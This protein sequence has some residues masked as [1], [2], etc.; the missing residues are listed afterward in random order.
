MTLTN[1]IINTGP[2]KVAKLLNVDPST[3]SIWRSRGALPRPAQ[4][5]RI[6][7]LTK[8]RVSYQEMVEGFDNA[9][10]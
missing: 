5:V 9:N 7:K 3:V 6:Y 10:K 8:G 1:W 2:K 4:M